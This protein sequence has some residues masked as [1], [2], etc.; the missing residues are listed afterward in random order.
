VLLAA[1]KRACGNC[2]V[3]QRHDT[4]ITSAKRTYIGYLILHQ[5]SAEALRLLR[6]I[7]DSTVITRMDVALEIPTDAEED[8]TAI[9]RFFRRRLTLPH[10]RGNA[11]VSTY[12][13]STYWRRGRFRTINATTYARIGQP[14]KHGQALWGKTL[15]GFAAR[16]EFRMRTQWLQ[17][18]GIRS[19]ADVQRLDLKRFLHRELR[20]TRLRHQRIERRHAAEIALSAPARIRLSLEE[21]VDGDLRRMT[22]QEGID[23]LKN[24]PWWRTGRYTEPLKVRWL[25]TRLIVWVHKQ[26]PPSP[27]PHTDSIAERREVSKRRRL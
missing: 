15:G 1:I 26:P 22:A 10:R 9:V 18:H 25:F 17:S 5:P 14:D 21:M 11:A 8:A 23:A 27:I 12:K 19:A 16:V 6:Q 24:C 13:D 3:I 4:R 7:E 20:L 2:P